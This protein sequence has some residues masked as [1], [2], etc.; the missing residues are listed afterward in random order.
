MHESALI[1][2]SVVAAAAALALILRIVRR[3][4]VEYLYGLILHVSGEE[5]EIIDYR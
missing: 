3:A 5:A 1:F 2:D 4:A